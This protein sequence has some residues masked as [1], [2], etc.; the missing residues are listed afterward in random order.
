MEKCFAE[1]TS[2]TLTF[3]VFGLSPRECKLHKVVNI[4]QPVPFIR[5]PD[6]HFVVRMLVCWSWKVVEGRKW[7]RNKVQLHLFPFSATSTLQFRIEY[8]T[9]F[10]P[11]K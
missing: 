9:F 4:Y 1:C 11:S 2:R 7:L 5:Q 6:M 10:S 8:C 3:I